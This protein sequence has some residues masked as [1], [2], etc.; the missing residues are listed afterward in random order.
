MDFKKLAS[1]LLSVANQ[2]DINGFEAE[3]DALTLAAEIGR[4]H[5]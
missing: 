3:A 2:A 5:V 1:T 4:A